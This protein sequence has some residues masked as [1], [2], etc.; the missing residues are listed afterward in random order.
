MNENV[1]GLSERGC[2]CEKYAYGEIDE[3]GEGLGTE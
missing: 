2:R 3:S 1:E